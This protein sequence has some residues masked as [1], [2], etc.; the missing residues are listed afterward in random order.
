MSEAITIVIPVFNREESIIRCL[1]SVAAQTY[2]PINLIV[3][4]NGSTDE[5]FARVTE[6]GRRN[7]G[8]SLSLNLEKELEKGA[9][10]ARNRG[11]EL[12]RT[13][14]VMF[15]DSDDTMRPKLVETAM[16]AFA[17]NP[18]ARLVH[19]RRCYHDL[20]GRVRVLPW[21]SKHLLKGH[22][23]HA[24]L[25]TQSYA[26][27]TSLFKSIGGWNRSLPVWNDWE[28]GVRLLLAEPETVSLR[29]VLVD[30]YAGRD[31]L[32]G[33][34]FS[35]RHGQWERSID[36]VR[37]IVNASAD[38]R[39][40]SLTR[41]VDYRAIVLAADYYREGKQRK[42]KKLRDATLQRFEGNK[43]QKMLMR[44]AYRYRRMGGRGFAI[45]ASL[46]F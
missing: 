22:I 1:D 32:T 18:K 4:D 30:V 23:F 14:K 15:F 41:M 9:S 5:T 28:A 6:W 10:A 24:I 34:K 11:L 33:A 21:R 37:S 42:G 2:R 31:S 44:L 27:K 35:D 40:E 36:A 3:V 20:F 12:V 7:A 16:R 38:C 17:E 46:A 26:V 43:F 25:S 13:D 29:N 19:W 39:R 8:N 45:I